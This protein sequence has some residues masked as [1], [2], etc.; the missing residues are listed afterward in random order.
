[1]WLLRAGAT[2]TA[3]AIF[4]PC[5]RA[6]RIPANTAAN[7]LI[8]IPAFGYPVL[9]L[10]ALIVVLTLGSPTISKEAARTLAV[11]AVGTAAGLA[12]VLAETDATAVYPVDPGGFKEI[13]YPLTSTVLGVG[14]H[15]AIA[16]VAAE[17]IGA[18]LVLGVSDGAAR[19]LS[20]PL[21]KA[22]RAAKRSHPRG[23]NERRG[24]VRRPKPRQSRFPRR[25]RSR[26]AAVARTAAAAA[27]SARAT[28]R[29]TRA[30]I[31]AMAGAA[32]RHT[33][34][35]ITR[36]H[37]AVSRRVWL[38]VVPGMV[39]AAVLLLA[40][41]LLRAETAPAPRPTLAFIPPIMPKSLGRGWITNV[42]VGVRSC[43][44][45]V[46]VG[47]T[48]AGS[49]ELFEDRHATFPHAGR[50]TLEVQSR[51]VQSV[52]V[53][54]GNYQPGGIDP[55]IA[56]ATS[57]KGFDP[58]SVT[59]RSTNGGR[60]IDISGTVLDWERHLPTVVVAFDADWLVSRG[61]GE[62]DL[63]LPSL[64]E[65]GFA[66]SLSSRSAQPPP[67]AGNR[68][69]LAFGATTL[70]ATEVKTPP[71][72]VLDSIVPTASP[73]STGTARTVCRARPATAGRARSSPGYVDGGG[74][75]QSKDG[76]QA[77]SLQSMR[78]R[79]STKSDCSGV[80]HLRAADAQSQRDLVLW[81]FGA[82]VALCLT[83]MIQGVMQP[84][85][86]RA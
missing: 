65:N 53:A 51:G 20:R 44:E 8:D 23:E 49:A 73:S 12:Y 24:R 46:R 68:G 58:N 57:V 36:L 78:E 85:R 15:V 21:R 40:H 34:A 19:R 22:R 80:A 33:E 67:Y 74:Y 71:S 17:I 38:L 11:I 45:P 75:I 54:A 48:L 79:A 30:V 32:S 69:Y 39:L 70:G 64:F 18:L 28:L 62:C 52:T 81:I 3:V 42:V 50:F 7:R 37:K 82:A 56:P 76:G 41:G 10:S 60:E 26:R 72:L 2:G 1:M 27:T 29:A 63:A 61:P 5:A 43:G 4:L 83:V 55:F 35:L 13:V 14:S 6:V 86:R 25:G 59:V 84:P 77:F 16:G 31:R 9:V 47:V 66:A